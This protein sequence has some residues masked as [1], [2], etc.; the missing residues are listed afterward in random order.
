[1]YLV[2]WLLENVIFY[3]TVE[4]NPGIMGR[5][6]RII[7]GV[8]EHTGIGKTTSIIRPS[9]DGMQGRGSQ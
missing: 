2:L 5:N 3:K 9:L 6:K 7:G 1:M 8:H 4:H